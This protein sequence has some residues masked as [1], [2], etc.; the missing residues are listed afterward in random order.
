[1]NKQEE[2]LINVTDG[3]AS[4]PIERIE[5]FDHIDS[6]LTDDEITMLRQMAFIE[7]DWEHTHELPE[8]TMDIGKP[9]DFSKKQVGD[10]FV[11]N[12]VN[13]QVPGYKGMR[14]ANVSLIKQLVLSIY[15]RNKANGEEDKPITI[16]DSGCSNG[17]TIFDLIS[18]LSHSYGKP[19]TPHPAIDCI[20]YV[21]IDTSE[22]M[23]ERA[24]ETLEEFKSIFDKIGAHL[25]GNFEFR[26]CDVMD[27][28]DEFADLNADISVS[29]L[30]TMFIPVHHR[31]HYFDGLHAA[32]R[33]G[34]HLV[35]TE[36]TLAKTSEMNDLLSRLYHIDK[37]RNGLSL[38]AIRRKHLSLPR[39][40]HPVQSEWTEDWLQGSG[41]ED[42]ELFWK[43][44]M[45]ESS[46]S[47]AVEKR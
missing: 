26:I 22:A 4:N 42:R 45:F 35:V 44:Y 7:G 14:S 29:V 36:K 3:L 46:I 28:A 38:E 6:N 30:M 40:L 18:A 34:G 2:R 39:F 10:T 12:I 9:Y 19:A 24:N 23:I 37:F 32:T 41:F 43:H 21:G 17:A 15:E 16:F 13:R 47:R 11:T 27:T 20:R 33:S 25:N 1:M 31:T 8:D 5:S